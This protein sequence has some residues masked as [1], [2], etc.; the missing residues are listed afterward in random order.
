MSFSRLINLTLRLEDLL[1]RVRR[2]A[3]FHSRPWQKAGDRR[4]HQQSLEHVSTSPREIA[5]VHSNSHDAKLLS[6]DQTA[7]G[8]PG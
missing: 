7:F 2:G 4:N 8:K 6:Q 1:V 3:R 5:V